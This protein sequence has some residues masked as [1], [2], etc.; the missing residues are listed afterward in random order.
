MGS[1]PRRRHALLT[2]FYSPFLLSRAPPR[3]LDR[4]R[5][6]LGLRRRPDPPAYRHHGAKVIARLV[7]NA[8][9]NANAPHHHRTTGWCLVK[10][11]GFDLV[12]PQF[13]WM[14]VALALFQAGDPGAPASCC[15][16]PPGMPRTAQPQ[17]DIDKISRMMRS[18][19]FAVPWP[20]TI[21]AL[22]IVIMPNFAAGI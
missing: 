19:F 7:P 20:G 18:F 12:C 5:A 13:G 14:A 2:M 15:R 17:S 11:L 4:H 16:Q 21:K 1:I 6:V 9:P 3:T 8:V 10:D 22:T